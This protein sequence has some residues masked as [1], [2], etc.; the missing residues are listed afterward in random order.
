MVREVLSPL[1]HD[2]LRHPKEIDQFMAD[3]A[4]IIANGCKMRLVLHED[5]DPENVYR[6]YE[7]IS[8]FS[9]L[10]GLSIDR[11]SSIGLDRRIREGELCLISPQT[12]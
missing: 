1:G 11:L 12:I 5:I 10:S 3:I 4:N 9:L 6:I 2:S 7:L 8:L